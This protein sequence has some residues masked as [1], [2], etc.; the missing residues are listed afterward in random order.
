[1]TLAWLCVFF[2][3]H[4][5]TKIATKIRGRITKLHFYDMP[6]PEF[7]VDKDCNDQ[8]QNTQNN[9]VQERTF[10]NTSSIALYS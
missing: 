4:W 7:S 1:M 5:E 2:S 10:K 3:V 6:G 9:E 8:T